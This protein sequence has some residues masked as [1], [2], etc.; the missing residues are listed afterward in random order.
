MPSAPWASPAV[1][2]VA[3]ASSEESSSSEASFT[4]SGKASAGV[5]EAAAEPTPRPPVQLPRPSRAPRL[6]PSEGGLA[7]RRRRGHTSGRCGFEL[8]PD[9]LAARRSIV[10]PPPAVNKMSIDAL[11]IPEADKP[12]LHALVT[13]AA[14]EDFKPKKTI[15]EQ[16]RHRM[17]A[18]ILYLE[19][20]EPRSAVCIRSWG[21]CALLSR[22]V[23]NEAT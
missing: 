7:T 2:G 9:P 1:E 22:K 14:K 19:A 5:P 17:A 16:K 3:S 20:H 13:A 23:N 12:K 8:S 18:A 4:S 21:A 6:P 11:G 15:S 10:G